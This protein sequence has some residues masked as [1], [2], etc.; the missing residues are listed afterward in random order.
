MITSPLTDKKQHRIMHDIM[1]KANAAA[2]FA[3]NGMLIWRIY[4]GVQWNNIKW[5]IKLKLPIKLF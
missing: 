5:S 4:K 2:R 1:K 3:F